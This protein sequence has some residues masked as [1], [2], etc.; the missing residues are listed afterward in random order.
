MNYVITA[1]EKDFRV[2]IVEMMTAMYRSHQGQDNL[3]TRKKI[4][5]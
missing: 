3:A 5:T 1:G 2:K 4:V